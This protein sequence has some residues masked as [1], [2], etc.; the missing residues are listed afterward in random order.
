MHGGSMER[1]IR[2]YRTRQVSASSLLPVAIT[3][4]NGTR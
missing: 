3:L 4:L 1:S 2:G